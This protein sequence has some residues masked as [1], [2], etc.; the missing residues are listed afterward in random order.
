MI[1]W[2]RVCDGVSASPQAIQLR[3]CIGIKLKY[4]ILRRSLWTAALRLD[5]QDV[6]SPAGTGGDRGGRCA[7]SSQEVSPLLLS[8]GADRRRGC[9][10]AHQAVWRGYYSTQPNNV[11]A[12]TCWQPCGYTVSQM[13]PQHSDSPQLQTDGPGFGCSRSVSMCTQYDATYCLSS[14]AINRNGTD[15]CG[16][17]ACASLHHIDPVSSPH[18]SVNTS[19]PSGVMRTVCSYCAAKPPSLV[20]TCGG[21]YA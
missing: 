11:A 1:S 7:R 17:T 9:V 2:R 5:R 6:H 16:S 15:P 14:I 10:A 18:G 3:R 19:A 4:L 8:V 20:T 21:A 13:L 12:S